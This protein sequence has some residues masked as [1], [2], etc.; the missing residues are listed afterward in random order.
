MTQVSTNNWTVTWTKGASGKNQ[1]IYIG[2]DETAVSKSCPN[3]TG[4][5]T[6][7]VVKNESLDPNA[8][9][10]SV[11]GLAAGTFYYFMLKES[12]G[13]ASAV[14]SLLTSCDLSPS[15]LTLNF[16]QTATVYTNVVSSPNITEVDYS[17]STVKQTVDPNC[18]QYSDA[19]SCSQNTHCNWV[20]TGGSCSGPQNCTN[21][22]DSTSCQNPPA[23]CSGTTGTCIGGGTCSSQRTSVS[24]T[25]VKG[26]NWEIMDCGVY[27]GSQATCIQ[28]QS[29]QWLANYCQWHA[30]SDCEGNPYSV[31]V[32]GAVSVS[33]TADR[34]YAYQTTATGV[35]VDP[36]GSNTITSYVY[37][38]VTPICS[39]VIHVSVLP[40]NAWWQVKDGDVITN[41]D[42]KASLPDY[43]NPLFDVAGGGGFPGVPSYGGSTDLTAANVSSKSWLVNSDYS[44]TKLYNSTFF[45]NAI[46]PDVKINN[47]GSTFDQIAFNNATADSDGYVWFEYDGSQNGG[48]DLTIPSNLDFGSNKVVLLVK[49]ADLDISGDINYTD[50]QGFF[51][52]VTTGNIVVDPSVGGGG[53]PNLEGVYVADGE[54][55]TG[56]TGAQDDSQLWIRGSVAAYGGFNLERDLGPDLNGTTPSELFEYAPEVDLMFPAKLGGYIINWREAAP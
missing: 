53:A 14:T 30:T 10:Y 38:G 19:H 52:G 4:E 37:N 18:G 7:C 8:Q 29:C 40:P 32:P 49:N 3:G 12:C 54:F 35:R 16:G 47:L 1:A 31:Q 20:T 46:P 13:S 5:G 34:S 56:T 45:L 15:S 36:S 2:T 42:L 23:I 26:C 41:G 33:P 21:Y 43:G 24:C 44:S 39:S 11:T 48:L 50:G 17:V 55:V 25:S 22:M 9:S 6:G 28:H 51:L 27:R